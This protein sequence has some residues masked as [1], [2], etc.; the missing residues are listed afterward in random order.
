MLMIT[1]SAV[2]K[3][4][5]FLGKKIDQDYGIRIFVTAGG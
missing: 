4:K 5:E 1:D 2:K 3:F